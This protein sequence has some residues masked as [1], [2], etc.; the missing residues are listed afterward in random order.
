MLGERNVAS[1]RVKVLQVCLFYKKVLMLRLR[2]SRTQVQVMKR[3]ASGPSTRSS[4]A[5]PCFW[6]FVAGIIINPSGLQSQ[7]SG[8][9]LIPTVRI[10]TPLACWK[11]KCTT[12]LGKAYRITCR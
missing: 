5:L 7:V 11:S 3:L 8:I 6:F 10:F 12:E 1:F 4:T 2:L 9:N